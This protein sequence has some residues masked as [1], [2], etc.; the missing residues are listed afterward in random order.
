MMGY[1]DLQPARTRANASADV[2]T[3]S[4]SACADASD[5][6]PREARDALSEE[7]SKVRARWYMF[8]HRG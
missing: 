8:Q 2:T 5:R 4:C 6:V 3:A 7:K 1:G